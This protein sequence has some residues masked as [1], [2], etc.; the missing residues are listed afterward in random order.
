MSYSGAVTLI[1]SIAQHAKPIVN[2]QTD[3]LCAQ[4]ATSSS[5][6]SMKWA[7]P[8][9]IGCLPPNE[10]A[11]LPHVRVADGEHDDKNDH[12]QK[13]EDAKRV[14]LDRPRIERRRLDVENH[15][16]HRDQIKAHRKAP[17][18]RRRRLDAAFVGFALM[19][20]GSR[21]PEESRQDGEKKR[22]RDGDAQ[23]D[24]DGGIRIHWLVKVFTSVVPYLL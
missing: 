7:G 22:R 4:R 1:I 6:A 14:H 8:T 2:G 9:D 10:T 20:I 21:A 24:R 18:D 19:R 23:V 15:E 12:L 16:E 17:R 3:E 5:R 13:P 11:L